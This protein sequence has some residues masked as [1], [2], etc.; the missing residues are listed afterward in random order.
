MEALVIEHG[1]DI[2]RGRGIALGDRDDIG[3]DRVPDRRLG[4]ESLVE[5]MA[6]QLARNVGMVEPRGDAVGD[7]LLELVVIEYG[8][9]NKGREL[10]C[11]PRD[12][13]RFLADARPYR[14]EAANG[15]GELG[16]MLGHETS[17]E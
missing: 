14:I 9:E 13:F 11:A 8:R 5:G 6:D 3:A 2:A 15:F 12:L 7:R 4:R 17:P 1:L 10:R 16:L